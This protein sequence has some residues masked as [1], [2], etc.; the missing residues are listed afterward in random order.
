LLYIGYVYVGS[1]AGLAAWLLTGLAI[2]SA[3]N[4]KGVVDYAGPLRTVFTVLVV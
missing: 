4:I 2:N 3:A 1:T